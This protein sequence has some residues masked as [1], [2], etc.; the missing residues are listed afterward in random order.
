MS[1]H[2]LLRIGCALLAGVPATTSWGQDLYAGPAYPIAVGNPLDVRL[3]D[4]NGDAKLDLVATGWTYLSF[5]NPDAIS[6]RMGTGTGQFGPLEAIPV[7][8]TPNR[9]VAAD[10][11]GDADVDL[12]VSNWIGGTVAIFAGDGSGSFAAPSTVS[13]VIT[14]VDL[15]AGDWNGDGK[16]DLLV[17]GGTGVVKLLLGNGAGSFVPL[18]AAPAGGSGFVAPCDANGDGKLDVVVAYSTAT[19]DAIRVLT[20]TGFGGF[21]LGPAWPTGTA[22]IELELGDLD[23]DGK[24]DVVTASLLDAT[25]SVH[26]ADG[27]GGFAPVATFATA[28]PSRALSL[29][30]F[31]GDGHLDLATANAH[32]SPGPDIPGWGEAHV[33][34]GD[35]AGH[36]TTTSMVP[37]GLDPRTLAAGDLDGDGADDL[38]IGNDWSGTVS[39]ARGG[40]SMVVASFFDSGSP[41]NGLQLGDLDGDGNLDLVHFR[42]QDPSFRVHLGDPIRGFSPPV[43][44]P[45]GG[46]SP[47]AIELGD[48]DHDG[49]L[50]VVALDA[51]HVCVSLGDGAGAFAMPAA[52]DVGGVGPTSIVLGDLDG[53]GNLDA[54]TSND[55][56]GD[57]SVLL[58]DGVGG[59]GAAIPIA[60]GP[61]PESLGVADLDGDGANDLVVGRNVYGGPSIE[62]S[63]AVL[64]ADGRAHFASPVTYPTAS[65]S[66][67][68]AVGDLD[69]DGDPDVFLTVNQF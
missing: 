9:V 20:G 3:V 67:E 14:P 29:G 6:I 54:A 7:D 51:S 15:A 22:P 39:I 46:T 38:A 31:D 23:E 41:A 28:L 8:I 19:S 13:T 58:G 69:R 34:R 16:V 45:V 49:V 53:D 66:V 18:A 57:V 61:G 17:S 26:L 21:S 37:T 62:S 36:F 64:L 2:D 5:G 40:K 59:L 43:S 32:P 33:A 1:H 10:F 44:F 63:I 48:V 55:G 68:L 60:A 12:A 56:S 27:L 47:R 35:G 4:V 50:D 24:T 42:A 11:D 65:G 52:F 30:D 25:A